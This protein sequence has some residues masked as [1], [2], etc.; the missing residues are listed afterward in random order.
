MPKVKQATK[1]AV[2]F[3]IGNIGRKQWPYSPP[4]K[5]P[6]C[7]IDKFWRNQKIML[8]NINIIIFKLISFCRELKTEQ[9]SIIA[10]WKYL[11]PFH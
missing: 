6:C 2:K 10:K 8:V 3:P 5:G 4:K 7:P 9:Y 1:C 11:I